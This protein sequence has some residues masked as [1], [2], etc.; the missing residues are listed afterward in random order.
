MHCKAGLGRTGTLI[1]VYAMKH[2]G[3]PPAEFIGWIRLCRPGSVLG[4]QQQFL[5]SV[6]STV[7]RWA[8]E[9]RLSRAAYTPIPKRNIERA[10]SY[11]CSD[12]AKLLSPE[13]KSKA[14]NGDLGQAERLISAKKTLQSPGASKAAGE[15]KTPKVGRG[16]SLSPV[17]PPKRVT[18]QT[19]IVF[20][21]KNTTVFTS[22]PAQIKKTK[23][24][25]IFRA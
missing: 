19:K 9:Y 23:S 11:G 1:G 7:Q 5:I 18:S 4:P 6:E 14:D 12:Y 25:S 17:S 13:E 20:V 22:P 21:S 24:R 10:E 2:F 8:S 15:S 3:F 16:K